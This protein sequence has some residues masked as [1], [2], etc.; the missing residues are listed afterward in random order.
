MGLVIH[1]RQPEI[2]LVQ[3]CYSQKRKLRCCHLQSYT[4][5]CGLSELGPSLPDPLIQCSLLN[6]LLLLDHLTFFCLTFSRC[7]CVTL[8]KN[9]Y[10]QGG[11]YF[12]FTHSKD[13]TESAGIVWIV[14]STVIFY[15][16]AYSLYFY[17]LT[18]L[19]LSNSHSI[20]YIIA[21]CG[22]GRSTISKVDERQWNLQFQ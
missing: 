12:L 7:F 17:H 1:R 10:K 21:F 22:E 8:T 16:W 19:L 15:L 11:P 5:S 13:V 3:H 9:K 6:A 4:T 20:T 2:Y 18:C 14:N